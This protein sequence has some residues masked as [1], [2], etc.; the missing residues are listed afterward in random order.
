MANAQ[1]LNRLLL[2]FLAAG[3]LLSIWAGLET[4]YPGLQSSCSVS[5]YVSCAKIDASAYTHTGPFPDWSIGVGGF[6][7]LLGLYVLYAR[8]YGLRYLQ[9]ILGLSLLGV[10]FLVYFAYVEV[11][12]I[13]GIC[14]VC[15]GAYLCGLGGF[16]TALSLVRLRSRP[17]EDEE[18][19]RSDPDD[20]PAAKKNKKGRK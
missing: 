5:S 12:L 2:V 8:T 7:L 18:E 20:R 4:T 16:G 15:T 14:P 13:G 10:G 1:T 3:L 9:A 11:V 17:D 6:L 19:E